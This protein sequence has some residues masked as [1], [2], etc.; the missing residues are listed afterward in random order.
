MGVVYRA[1][2]LKLKRQVALKFTLACDRQT[3]E[4]FQRE[5]QAASALNHPNI[6]TTYDIDEHEGRPFLAMELLEGRTLHDCVLDGPLPVDQALDLAIQIADGL[7]AAHAKGTLHRDVKPANIFVTSD[8]HA[9]LL[10]FGLAKLVQEMPVRV[11][12]AEPTRTGAQPLTSPG[13]AAG[14]VNYMSPEQ[15]RGETL[16]ARS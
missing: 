16:D 10:D 7:R 15:A 11:R 3:L 1:E 6:C 4:R 2:D 9:K 13:T 14:T 5:A 8:G 12:G